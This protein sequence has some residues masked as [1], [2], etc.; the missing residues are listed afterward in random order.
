MDQLATRNRTHI[1][2][3]LTEINWQLATRNWQILTRNWQISTR[4]WQISTRNWQISTRNWQISTDNSQLTTVNSQL[5]NINWQLATR[6]WQISTC[7][8]QISTDNSQ[9]ATD[10]LVYLHPPYL[11][12]N[13]SNMSS[14]IAEGMPTRLLCV[15]YYEMIH[16]DVHLYLIVVSA[17]SSKKTLD[18]G[19][20]TIFS[21]LV[22]FDQCW[23][24]ISF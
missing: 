22:C 11:W 21:V 8:W 14:M 5:T 13:Q 23:A 16:S 17:I 19:H 3:Q 7:N 12:K 6:N 4:N 10:K 9:L 2:S 18:G 1:S 15:D 20:Y 24:S